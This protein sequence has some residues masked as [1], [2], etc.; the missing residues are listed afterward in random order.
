MLFGS[1][2]WSV[3]I[4]DEEEDTSLAAASILTAD[5]DTEAL[6]TFKR[7]AEMPSMRAGNE[8]HIR[9]LKFIIYN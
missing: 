6:A 3:E 9:C 7:N 8:S 4:A 5:E 2:K 1:T